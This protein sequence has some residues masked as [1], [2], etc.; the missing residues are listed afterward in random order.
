MHLPDIEG[1]LMPARQKPA[2]AEE[3]PALEP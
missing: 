3:T 2:R 1:G